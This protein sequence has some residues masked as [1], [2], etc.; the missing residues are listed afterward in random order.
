M[1]TKGTSPVS[2]GD[3]VVVRTT[4]ERSEPPQE[5]QFRLEKEYAALEKELNQ[6]EDW[7]K[8]EPLQAFPFGKGCPYQ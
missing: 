3:S 7:S 1:R 2:V 4:G 5:E 6:H 8:M